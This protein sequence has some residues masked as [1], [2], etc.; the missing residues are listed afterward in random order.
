[1]LAAVL[2]PSGE[3]TYLKFFLDAASESDDPTHFVIL[4]LMGMLRLLP[5][6][7]ITPFFGAR[8]LP[9]P[10]KAAMGLT[11]YLILM[12][13][14]LLTT[15]TNLTVNLTLFS[16]GIKELFI[17]TLMG[18]LASVPF[19]VAETAGIYIDHQRGGSSLM[20]QD[21]HVQNQDSPLGIIWNY[22]LIVTFYVLDGQFIFI[23]AIIRSYTLVPIDAWFSSI[24]FEDDSLF[25]EN[26]MGIMAYVMR[27]GIKIGSPALLTILMTE[28]FLGI[29]NRLA[30]NVMITFLGMPLK[31]L[32]GLGIICFGWGYITNQMK[33]EMMSWLLKMQELVEMFGYG[34]RPGEGAVPWQ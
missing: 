7:A 2:E 23:E 34:F 17:G 31:S 28:V 6:L 4:F 13:H 32:F 18:I 15:S 19:F 10:V 25:W 24:F 5:I 9:H 26:I 12:P 29:A 8:V 20:V 14:I 11:L 3:G 1:M 33:Y 16:Y 30:P 27:I 21:P 22:I